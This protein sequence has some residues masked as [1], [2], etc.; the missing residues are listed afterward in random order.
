MNKD[1]IVIEQRKIEEIK[2]HGQREKDRLTMA[3][4]E[5]ET[6][7]SN[8]K[9]YS[10]TRKGKNDVIKWLQTNCQAKVALDYC[11]GLGGMTLELAKHGAYAYGIDISAEEIKTATKNALD[12]GYA[13]QTEFLVMDAENLEFDDNFF[14][15]IV[16]SGV[17]H[18]LDLDIAYSE[19]SRVLK[20]DGK[21]IC[22]EAL[23][24]NP[25]INLYRRMTPHLRTDWEK[26]HILTLRE[27][28]N[29]KVYF[30]KITI[31]YYYLFSIIAVLFR[32]TPIFNTILSILET[33][34]SLILRMPIIQRLAWQMTFILSDPKKN[35]TS[36]KHDN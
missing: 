23:G 18:H 33:I 15:I 29:G 5:F 36:L 12:N 6:K 7:Y 27:V 24:Y 30:N 31:S 17:L 19:L 4:D 14:D 11:C 35:R 20:S 9:F 10:I 32:K 34:D 26:D 13:E 25:V 21:I 22:M 3:H 28:N 2:F 1:K 16:C 8:K